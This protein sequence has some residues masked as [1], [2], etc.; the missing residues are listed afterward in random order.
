MGIRDADK[1]L[2][3][4][5]SISDGTSVPDKFLPDLPVKHVDV[6]KLFTRQD[7]IKARNLMV[8]F[9]RDYLEMMVSIREQVVN[10]R[11]AHIDSYTC[12]END[13]GYW[14]Y[15]LVYLLERDPKLGTY[16]SSQ[17]EWGAN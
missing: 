17:W 1:L 16:P 11:M 6:T 10:P 2:A 13:P 3:A 7:V 14:A 12:Q 15:A 8:K 9:A 4:L 5:E